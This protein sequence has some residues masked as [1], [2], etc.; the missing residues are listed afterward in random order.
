MPRA[1][2]NTSDTE[3]IDL[4]SCPEGYVL[5][6]RLTYGQVL[7]RRDMVGNMVM[8]QKG[9]GQKIADMAVTMQM[10]QQ[11]VGAFEL[12]NCVV[13]HNLEDEDGNLLNFKSLTILDTLDPRVGQEIAGHIDRMNQFEDEFPNS[14]S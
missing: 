7:Q 8:E 12:A 9:K 2:V 1:T 5:L 10:A 3:R 14:E 4:K 13:E 6:K 11:K